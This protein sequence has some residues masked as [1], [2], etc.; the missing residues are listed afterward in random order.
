MS[1]T[2]VLLRLDAQLTYVFGGAFHRPT[3]FYRTPEGMAF[4]MDWLRG[5]NWVVSLRGM[6]AGYPFLLASYAPIEGM[7]FACIIDRPHTA[8]YEHGDIAYGETAPIAVALLVQRLLQRRGE[9]E[10]DDKLSGGTYSGG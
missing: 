1:D 2:K 10:I 7:H 8:P 6:P 5:E 4:L 3:A 9:L